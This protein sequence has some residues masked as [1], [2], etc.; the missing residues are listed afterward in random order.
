M[1]GRVKERAGRVGARGEGRAGSAA[2]RGARAQRPRPV[3]TAHP[4]PP[5]VAPPVRLSPA[6]GPHG[7]ER[8]PCAADWAGGPPVSRAIPG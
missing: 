8:M 5:C 4:R 1:G 7:R 3:L 6:L 2:V